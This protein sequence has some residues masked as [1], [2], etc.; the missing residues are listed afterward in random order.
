MLKSKLRFASQTVKKLVYLP[1]VYSNPKLPQ[2]TERQ[3][4]KI[5]L[6]ELTVPRQHRGPNQKLPQNRLHLRQERPRPKFRRLLGAVHPLR[7]Q[8]HR[9]LRKQTT[10]KR[11]PRN[12]KNRRCNEKE[13]IE[14]G[15][16]YCGVKCG[17]QFKRLSHKSKFCRVQHFRGRNLPTNYPLQNPPVGQEVFPNR[18][19]FRKT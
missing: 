5:L 12:E 19:T 13:E 16:Y 18:S 10:K 15:V 14:A 7:R 9:R 2:P 6:P 11:T 8:S 4:R 3:V 17:L 1:C